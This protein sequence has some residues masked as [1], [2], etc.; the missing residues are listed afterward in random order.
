MEE[1]IKKCITFPCNGKRPCTTK[2]NA[3]TKSVPMKEGY[4]FG[5]LCGKINDIIIIDCDLLKP[6][7]SNKKYLCGVEAW[8]ILCEM[9][10]ILKTMS[11]PIVQTQ[12]GGLHL[13]FKYNSDLSSGI[14]KIDGD[15]FGHSGK[16]VKI[17]ILSDNKFVVGPGSAGYK[18]IKNSQ[19]FEPPTLPYFLLDLFNSAS[20]EPKTEIIPKTDTRN[21]ERINY[22]SLKITKNQLK[23]TVN[24]I[25]NKYADD[26]DEWIKIIW[27][28]AETA[29]QNGY[30]AIDIAD[31]FSQKSTKYIGQDDVETIYNQNKG[32]ITYGTLVH[33]S[34]TKKENFLNTIRADPPSMKTE[35]LIKDFK[36]F[37]ALE[38]IDCIIDSSE[39]GDKRIFSLRFKDGSK[40]N[41]E[42]FQNN[43]I[44]TFDNNPQGYLQH[45]IDIECDLS[46]IHSGF[47]DISKC[48]LKD[49]NTLDFVHKSDKSGEHRIRCKYPWDRKKCYFTKHSNDK[50]IGNMQKNKQA[51]DVMLNDGLKTGCLQLLEKRYNMTVNCQVANFNFGSS[52]KHAR[53]EEQ[54][55]Q[56]LLEA[57][58][59]VVDSFKFSDNSKLGSFDGL[60]VCSSINGLWRKE[61]NGKVEKMIASRIKKHVGGLTELELK[62]IETHSNIQSLRKMFVKEII[63]DDFENKI[64]ENLEIFATQQ[65]VFDFE[66]KTLRPALPQDFALTNCGWKYSKE[67]SERFMDDVKEFFRKLFPI[68]EE[69]M[70]VVTFISS[71]LH[72]HRLDKKF[73]ILTDKRNGNNGKSTLLTMLRTFFGDYLKGSTKFI[74]R[75]A[76]DKDKDSHDAGLEPLK[77]KRVMLADELKKNMKLDE[78]L[79]KN[80]TGGEYEVEGRRIGKA[81]QFKFTWQAGIIMVFNEGDCPKFDSTDNAFMNRIIVGPMRSKFMDC[82]KDNDLTYTYKIDETVNSK[83]H[84]EKWC[85]SLLDYFKTYSTLEGLTRIKIPASMT[86]WKE[87]IISG[88]NE[89]ADW[90]FE[91][92]EKGTDNDFVSLN[93][94][95]DI[96]KRMNGPR[97]I[98]DRDFISMSKALFINKRVTVKEQHKFK[99]D[100]VRKCKRNVVLNYKI[101]ID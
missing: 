48:I 23:D 32:K 35:I 9:F 28:I 7:E 84:F 60:F 44:T 17:D 41:V 27:A 71:L 22:D 88:N 62:F 21:E 14:Q 18:F 25:P 49:L 8:N 99:E 80:L 59:G 45:S 33:Y 97:G 47:G 36:T 43:L 73:L 94:L 3:L 4:N 29:H 52:E 37:E 82:E 58:P 68:E 57:H 46:A 92:I 101:K 96:Y 31:Q 56:D 19:Y 81:D 70:V 65:G 40:K 20:Q 30:D 55:I 89:L 42:V 100:G 77:G 93:D 53:S 24:G 6:K 69:R 85:S 2:W 1:F 83:R 61:H 64:D 13:Y 12:S 51:V 95:K 5:V 75:G 54:F 76:F 78:G 79:I 15:V 86:E 11:I 10:T 72:G 66:S 38:H 67:D 34:T 74:C 50:Q 91:N 26:R 98:S 16:K 63:D 90:I 39:K 87:E